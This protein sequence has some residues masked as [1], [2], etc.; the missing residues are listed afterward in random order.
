MFLACSVDK[1]S[2]L[3]G[4]PFLYNYD[5]KKTSI[6]SLKKREDENHTVSMIYCQND[7]ILKK[8]FFLLK[9][10]RGDDL[11]VCR[12][13]RRSVLVNDRTRMIHH[14]LFVFV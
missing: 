5:V 11:E 3:Y 8:K 2:S 14:F 1:I 9:R 7:D 13:A 4:W 10:H 12:C 6:P